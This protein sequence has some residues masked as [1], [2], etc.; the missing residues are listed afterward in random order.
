M[1]GEK[2]G[3]LE[4]KVPFDGHS[5]Q[6]KGVEILKTDDNMGVFTSSLLHNVCFGRGLTFRVSPAYTKEADVYKSQQTDT[7]QRPRI[8]AGHKYK[9]H[10]CNIIWWRRRRA[11]LAAG[12][13]QLK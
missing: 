11:D 9:C 10:T 7:L 2:N 12:Q 13:L 8:H 5:A 1:G 4:L 3:A 6:V